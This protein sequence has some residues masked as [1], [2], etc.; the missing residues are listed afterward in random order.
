MT[1]VLQNIGLTAIDE[2]V[3]LTLLEHPQRSAADIA[4]GIGKSVQAVRSAVD[5]LE[6]LGFVSRAVAGGKLTAA[7][8]DLA[9]NALVMRRTEE[10]VAAQQHAQRLAEQFPE[11]LRASPGEL[12]GIVIG[13][14][15]VEAQFV[16]LVHAATEE[17]LVLD[18]PPYA[19]KVDR[20]NVAE[21]DLLGKGAPVRGIYAPEAFELPGAFDQAL[22]AIGQGEQARV[23]AEV[24]MK[25][26]IGDRQVALLPLTRSGVVDSALTVRAPM[27]VAALVQLFE[28][29]WRQAC[30]LTDWTPGTDVPVGDEIDEQLLALLATG[31][32]DEA[33]ARELGI[34]V[35][36]LGR[37]TADLLSNLG[38]RNRFQAGMQAVR[39]RP[40]WLR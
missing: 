6:E 36:T 21:T 1:R 8:P 26:A 4:H 32:K 27:V 35:R 37:R 22:V 19:Q 2:Q 29:M 38:A 23:H 15:A 10:L 39:R 11:E 31:M 25:L 40:E 34:S 20:S 17:L 16:Q 5:R 9:V 24:P 12:V 14:A 18:R 3:Y 30:P 33:I 7:R 13:K 28:M